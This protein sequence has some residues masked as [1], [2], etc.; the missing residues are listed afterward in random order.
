M[1][2]AEFF[3]WLVELVVSIADGVRSFFMS[4]V[5]VY[6]AVFEDESFGDLSIWE[7]GLVALTLWLAWEIF[8]AAGDALA[9]S[10]KQWWTER[11]NRNDR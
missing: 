8:T 1:T 6:R 11:G 10:L 9:E 2:V 7:V 3:N 4:Y 5:N